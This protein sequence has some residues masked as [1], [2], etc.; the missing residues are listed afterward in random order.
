MPVLL[1]G[2]RRFFENVAGVGLEPAGVVEGPDVTHL[3]YRVSA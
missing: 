1:G 3:K 2:G